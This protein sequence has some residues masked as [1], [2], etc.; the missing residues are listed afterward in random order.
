MS[1]INKTCKI[2]IVYDFDGTL[3]PG[4]MQEHSLLPELDQTTERFWQEVQQKANENN[5][6]RISCYMYMLLKKSVENNR[7]LTRDRLTNHGRQLKLFPGLHTEE[8]TQNWFNRLNAYVD[9]L[10]SLDPETNCIIE[11]YIISSGLQEMLE[12]TVIAKNIKKIFASKFYFDEESGVA[13]WPSQIINYTSKTQYLFRISKNVLDQQ[14]EEELNR[15]YG[16][17]EYHIP[18]NRIMFL[19]DGETDIPCFSL[20]SKYRGHSIAVFDQES[21]D[22]KK[23]QEKAMQLKIN[24]RVEQ[25]YPADYREQSN[26]DRHCKAVISKMYSEFIVSTLAS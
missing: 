10:P 16:S 9:S 13:V 14:D 24:K 26:L 21:Q 18:F 25:V 22:A 4:N 1:T 3:S 7:P 12:A 23:L 17:H 2:A 15:V 20:V 6:D 5:I 8:V 19:G 11:H